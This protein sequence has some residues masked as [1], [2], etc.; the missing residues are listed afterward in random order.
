M[1]VQEVVI[2]SAAR[3]AIGRFGGAL[4]SAQ[5]PELAAAVVRAAVERAKVDSSQVDEVVMGH[6]FVSGEAPNVA[7][8]AVL[9]ADFPA[10]IPAHG[11]ER[12]CG[13]GLQA[14]CDATMQIQTGN[15]QI[16]VAGGVE[17]MSNIEYYVTGARWGMRMGDQ[18][19]C[20]RW[21]RTSENISTHELGRVPSM[22]HTAAN[23]AAKLGITREEQDRFAFR[24]QQDCRAAMEAGKFKDEIV[25]LTLQQKKGPAVFDTDEHPRPD[26][27][28]ESLARL[29]PVCGDT[30][31]A[32]NSSGMNDGAAAC[33]LMAEQTAVTLGLEPLG[34]VRAWAVAG[35][36]P[37]YMGLGPVPAVR[38]VLAKAGLTLADMDVIELNEA[39]A[40]QALGVIKELGITDLSNMN[41]NGS[42]I[43]LGHPIGATGARIMTTLLYEMRRR[44]ARYG[45][46]TLC[47]GGG[48]GI[49]AIIERK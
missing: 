21:D 13:S 23:V 32:G 14:I 39:F 26:T 27:T 45:L 31:T 10:E 24:S 15:A 40:A 44:G 46:E 34:Y 25:P 41:V 18:V 5:A 37:A 47:I 35:V 3:T 33:V 20:D 48:Q 22:L 1:N 28:L 17:S 42:G 16:V 36:H 2:V 7:R 29:K 19:F 11:V 30:V 49:A 6:T 43:A 12:Q 8:Q 4:C 9:L 38:K